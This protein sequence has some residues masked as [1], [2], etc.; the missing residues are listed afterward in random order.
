MLTFP[1]DISFVVQIV[2]FLVLWFGLKRLLFDPV[3]QVIEEREARTT[4]TEREAAAMKAAVSVT[5]A[6]Y[7]Q[8]ML[9]VRQALAADAE[10]AHLAIQTEEREVLA[11]AR[12]K[13]S[14]ELSQLRDS[15]Q[16]QADGVREALD[17]EAGTLAGEMLTRV[18]ERPLA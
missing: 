11:Q 10:A 6:E 7:E 12:Q 3:V 18:M 16:R 1:P 14:A 9:Q 13:S 2:S 15:L 5:S 4:G 8:R 17:T